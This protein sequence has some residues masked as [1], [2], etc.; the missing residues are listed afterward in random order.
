MI[1][2]AAYD[3]DGSPLAGAAPT[4]HV[5]WNASSGAALSEPAIDEVEDAAGKYRF[6][7]PDGVDWAGFVDFGEDAHQFHRY[8]FVAS[9]DSDCFPLYDADGVPL[10]GVVPTWDSY[11]TLDDGVSAA[12][13]DIDELGLGVYRTVVPVGEGGVVDG[14]SEA[15]PRYTALL[16]GDSRP[17]VT[18]VSPAAGSTI[19]REDQ[20]TVDVTDDSAL[21]KRIQLQAY[22]PG[23]TTE[24]VHDGTQFQPG[25]R[26]G[27][28]RSAI[29]GG[30]R[31]V[32]ARDRKWPVG[33]LTFEALVIDREGNSDA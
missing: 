22:F 14:T 23:E 25:Y 26:R 28:T 21:F 16:H 3:E 33:T 6:D 13:P 1:V 32:L 4:W 31:Y 15:V 19:Q 30:Y 7:P 11:V 29:I 5:L 8:H 2:L 18:I 12:E 17:T 10:A 27:S 24:V 20:I 9:D